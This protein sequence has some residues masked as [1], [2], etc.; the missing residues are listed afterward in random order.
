MAQQVSAGNS[1]TRSMRALPRQLQIGFSVT[2]AVALLALIM[3]AFAWTAPTQI[4]TSSTTQSGRAMTFSYSADVPQ[5]PAYDGT[6]V[7]SPDP[8]F[9]KLTNTVDVQTGLR[10]R[11]GQHDGER[12]AVHAERM[13]F[14]GAAVR[15]DRH[16][17]RGLRRFGDPRLERPGRPRPGGRRHDRS[18]RL[19][20]DRGRGGQHPDRHRPFRPEDDPERRT[21]GND[22]QR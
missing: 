12:R 22:D 1:V 16:H 5:S 11:S 13:A 2:A 15:P 19:T 14:D 21:A 18:S 7:H 4:L 17:R 3:A 20:A 6:T 10:R 9:R 8:V